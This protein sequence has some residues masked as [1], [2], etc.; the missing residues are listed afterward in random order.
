[1]KYPGELYCVIALAACLCVSAGYL[2]AAW[3][4]EKLLVTCCAECY[5]DVI[6]EP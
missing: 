2:M 3:Y 6:K 5:P 1:M 4:Y